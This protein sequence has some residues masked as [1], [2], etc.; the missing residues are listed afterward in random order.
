MHSSSS[1]SKAEASLKPIDEGT[2]WAQKLLA[3]QDD[4]STD[5]SAKLTL[6]DVKQAGA[7]VEDS[8]ALEADQ[9]QKCSAQCH[10]NTE[11]CD[12]SKSCSASVTA[13]VKIPNSLSEQG[14]MHDTQTAS[15]PGEFP[16][17][18]DSFEWAAAASSSALHGHND[19]AA[20][21]RSQEEELTG[22]AHAERDSQACKQSSEDINAAE[23]PLAV[24]NSII[25]AHSVAAV[26]HNNGV[27][28][29]GY[30]QN[31]GGCPAEQC[32][33]SHDSQGYTWYCNILY[34]AL[35]MPASC[36]GLVS[37]GQRDDAEGLTSSRGS[38][39][40][41]Q[42]RAMHDAAVRMVPESGE[43]LET[44]NSSL[45]VQELTLARLPEHSLS[46]QSNTSCASKDFPVG[47]ADA[48]SSAWI[49]DKESWQSLEEG[50][51]RCKRTASSRCNSGRTPLCDALVGQDGM[52]KSTACTDSSSGHPFHV[53]GSTE[54]STH[55]PSR[56]DGAAGMLTDGSIV[57]GVM[58]DDGSH[59]QLVAS[60]RLESEPSASP[61]EVALQYAY[62]A[63]K[64]LSRSGSFR[65]G[66]IHDCPAARTF[67][68][69]PAKSTISALGS[70]Q[71]GDNE[72]GKSRACG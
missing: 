33:F 62:H 57:R 12:E 64:R 44:G 22:V 66:N 54:S 41:F 59:R 43:A 18:T 34:V 32:L 20:E 5:V 49:A 51:M 25:A 7:P 6:E 27:W 50:T 52:H 36:A 72:V 56:D 42:E 28:D 15:S 10:A 71:H 37:T 11:H 55:Q 53:Q 3:A 9:L 60:S 46:A 17:A 45:S 1:M 14:G 2:S 47:N 65:Q 26:D 31:V 8:K 39:H 30:M 69:S 40:A 38:L 4:G 29:T 67:S 58:S 61:A 70:I 48:N 23:G 13:V 63:Q 68:L 35:S 16:N 24:G 21:T 19:V